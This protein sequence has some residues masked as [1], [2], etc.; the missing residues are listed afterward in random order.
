MIYTVVRIIHTSCEQFT[1]T[2]KTGG[3]LKPPVSF[4]NVNCSLL[5]VEHSTVER[6]T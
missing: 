3:G 5:K 1:L 2:N 4:V 6:A